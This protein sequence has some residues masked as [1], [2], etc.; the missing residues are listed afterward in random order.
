MDLTFQ[1]KSTWKGWRW[2]C[3]WLPSKIGWSK[4][5]IEDDASLRSYNRRNSSENPFDCALI[6]KL[7]YQAFKAAP[8][9][10]C[11]IIDAFHNVISF[12]NGSREE[13]YLVVMELCKGDLFDYIQHIPVRRMTENDARS[14]ILSCHHYL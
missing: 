5:R 4:L 2:C 8:K 12:S 3:V 6:P 1:V 11:G 13:R 9:F 14:A 10:V 7:A